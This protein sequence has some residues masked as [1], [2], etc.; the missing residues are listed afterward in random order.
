MSWT[1]CCPGD[2][3]IITRCGTDHLGDCC[4][5][6]QFGSACCGSKCT[7]PQACCCGTPFTSPDQCCVNCQLVNKCGTQCPTGSAFEQCCGGQLINTL[8][9]LCCNNTSYSASTWDCCKN[10]S[11]EVAIQK[12]S[13]CCRDGTP[14]DLCGGQ[15]PTTSQCCRNNTL[16]DLCGG[17]CPTADQQCCGGELH[18]KDRQWGDSTGIRL[19]VPDDI[20]S[21]VN[22]IL[23]TINIQSS[24]M[25]FTATHRKRDCCRDGQTWVSGGEAEDKFGVRF[26]VAQENVPVP[27]FAMPFSQPITGSC[28]GIQ[29]SGTFQLGLYV[30]WNAVITGDS[31]YRTKCDGTTCSYYTLGGTFS[32]I[33]SARAVAEG[34]ISYPPYWDGGCAGIKV[35]VQGSLPLQI[36]GGTTC[37]GG[38][39]VSAALG[40]TALTITATC[41][42]LDWFTVVYTTTIPTATNL[43]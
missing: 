12:S 38:C 33:V 29:F 21:M 41:D 22:S 32:G 10:G 17:Q 26:V 9:Y 3:Q 36:S 34:C 7:I 2:T 37:E 19:T 5:S 42:N 4:P 14:V 18:P 24:E 40:N 25:Q 13:Q 28:G 30:G 27:G 31:T 1:Q 16:Y 20:R 23:A 6:D 39:T 35:V 8:F 43:L 11:T 15:C